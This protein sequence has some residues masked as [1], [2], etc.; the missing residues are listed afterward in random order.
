M[1]VYIYSLYVNFSFGLIES[2]IQKKN[3]KPETL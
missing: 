2:Y 3:Q 1:Y